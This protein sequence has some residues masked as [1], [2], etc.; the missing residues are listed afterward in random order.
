M[1]WVKKADVLLTLGLLKTAPSLFH[2]LLFY[3]VS[4]NE[5]HIQEYRREEAG[6][7]SEF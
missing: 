6:V 5:R 4:M 2:L 7:G 3:H 1:V